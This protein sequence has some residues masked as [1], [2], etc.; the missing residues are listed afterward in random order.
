M[1]RNLDTTA[2][3]SFVAVA[4]TGGVTRAAGLLN[5]TQSAV[6]MQLKRL[7]ESLGVGLFDRSARSI[8]LTSQGEL[9][10]SYARRMLE[11]NDEAYGKL[12]APD[13]EGEVTLG[14]PHDIV[15]PV[16]PIVLQRFA[17]AYPRVRVQLVSSFTRGLVE[18]FRRGAIDIIL[19][20]EDSV[21]EGGETLMK[22]PL[23]WVGAPNGQ[24]WKK[25]PLRLAYEESCIF[26]QFV[27][28]RLDEVGIPW[29]MAVESN[30][31]RTIEATVSADLAV[32]T[33][34][35]G[36]E[37]RHLERIDHGGHLPRLREMN[38]NLYQAQL[39]QG[40]VVKD[41][42]KFVRDGF[43]TLKSPVMA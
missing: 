38:I 6:S 18:D 31:S 1:A 2:L 26:R 23:I 4:D 10:L 5:L 20:T 22:V 11:L 9:L 7:E 3:R 43:Y 35:E 42:A 30:F 14:V 36:T 27:Q 40:P 32:H 37:P 13:Y 29:E 39:D 21:G 33:M 19:T 28:R 24:A 17:A 12:T 34:L 15:Y 41:L 25:R 8:S 16:I